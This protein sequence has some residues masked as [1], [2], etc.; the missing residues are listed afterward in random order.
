[1]NPAPERFDEV[2]LDRLIQETLRVEPSPDFAARVRA[3]IAE[4]AFDTD[5]REAL[6]VEPSPEFVARVRA[7]V[8]RHP[9]PGAWVFPWRGVAL[10]LAAAAAA[11]VTVVLVR[12]TLQTREPAPVAASTEQSAP[13]A[14]GG[15][16][17][18][19]PVLAAAAPPPPVMAATAPVRVAEPRPEPEVLVNPAEVAAFRNLLRALDS[20]QLDE[21]VDLGSLARRGPAPDEPLT[22]L[23][24][25]VV[26]RVDVQ[27]LETVVVN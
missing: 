16:A 20:E 10:G 22:E 14:A 9:I 8:A 27:P 21:E 6:N 23:I 11:I 12:P 19:L 1:M 24:A 17:I 3:R 25:V 26:E 2:T 18:A 7:E 4:S 15:A 5:V 13:A